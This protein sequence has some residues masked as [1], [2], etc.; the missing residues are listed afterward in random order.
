MLKLELAPSILRC[1]NLSSD[2]PLP[3]PASEKEFESMPFIRAMRSVRRH[4]TTTGHA[5]QKPCTTGGRYQRIRQ[6]RAKA[7][8]H[9]ESQQWKC[10]PDDKAALRRRHD[11]FTLRQFAGTRH[12]TRQKDDG[13]RRAGREKRVGGRAQRKGMGSWRGRRAASR[14]REAAT[15][16]LQNAAQQLMG[17]RSH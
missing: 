8:R 17:L 7:G 1:S 13:S 9:S 5:G 6:S 10:V 2:M 14:K 11:A 15:R 3:L 4:T 16:D 12:C